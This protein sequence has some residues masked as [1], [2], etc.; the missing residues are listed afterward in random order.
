[1]KAVGAIFRRLILGLLLAALP[2]AAAARG[3]PLIVAFGD[4]LTAGLGVPA[5]ESY[6]ADLEAEMA[7]ERVPGRVVNLGV[8]GDTTT[9]GL[10]RLPEVLRLHPQWVIL[11][12]GG[13][14]GLRG[15]P[16]ATTRANLQRMIERL[17]AAHVH[18]LLV[19]MSL[20]PNYGPEYIHAFQQVF[21]ALAREDRLP[22]L[23]FLYQD[24][25]PQL[26]AHPGLLQDDGIHASA[27]GN[28]I[29]AATVWRYLKPLLRQE[30]P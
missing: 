15:L 6:P 26:R 21:A 2:A 24:L 27:A 25:V 22:F 7:R 28:R 18:I 20:P 9:D 19:G 1:M 23:P 12:F 16:V 10:A 5:S 3:T 30:T 11:E 14:D 13:N 29:V 17:R 4:S 8:S